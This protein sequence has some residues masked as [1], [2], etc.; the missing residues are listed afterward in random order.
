[1]PADFAA[2]QTLDRSP[3]NLPIQ[4][5]PL[6]GREK[7]VA[8]ILRLLSREEVRLV[9]LIGPGGTGKTRLGLQVAAE[10]SDLFADG[11]Y[12]VNLAPISDPT[13]VVPTIAQTLELKESGDQPL[14]D[15]LQGFLQDKQ[16]LLLVNACVILRPNNFD[17]PL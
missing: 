5:T 12:F 8:A 13:F 7:E 17:P 4:A 3:H 16:L 1:L 15:L 10:L 14:L 11:V 6:I 9:T 2:L